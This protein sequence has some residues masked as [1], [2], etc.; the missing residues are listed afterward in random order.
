MRCADYA[1]IPVGAYSGSCGKQETLDHTLQEVKKQ[2]T[3]LIVV[4]PLKELEALNTLL[5]GRK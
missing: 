1:N 4:D 3:E 5:Q 2:R